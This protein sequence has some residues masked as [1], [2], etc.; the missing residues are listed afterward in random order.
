MCFIVCRL[1]IS[2][3]SFW[4]REHF[5]TS[6]SLCSEAD[7]IC[8][9]RDLGLKNAVTSLVQVILPCE[10][11]W[12][13]DSA[14]CSLG[15]ICHVPVMVYSFCCSGC[16]PGV[17]RYFNWLG[18]LPEMSIERR[19][20]MGPSILFYSWFRDFP[21]LKF[22]YTHVIFTKSGELKP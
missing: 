13:G 15:L 21:K 17:S 9:K 7:R 19:V 12:K 2:K 1:C 3:D 18:W 20:S 10:R 11:D 5:E 8:Q 22:Y 4:K 16:D 6:L 14:L